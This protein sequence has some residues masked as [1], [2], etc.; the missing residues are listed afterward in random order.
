MQ[1]CGYRNKIIRLFENKN[2]KPSMHALDSKS[3]GAEKS[4]QKFD[5]NIGERVKLRRQKSD[6]F[7]KIIIEKDEIINNELFIEYF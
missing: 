2:I 1:L 3:D 5:E 7:S 6:R 4:E